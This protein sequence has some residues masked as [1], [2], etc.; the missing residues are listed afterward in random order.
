MS[1]ARTLGTNVVIW[2]VMCAVI[3]WIAGLV[4]QRC[5]AIDT[6]VTR[7]RSFERDARVYHRL[8]IRRWKDRLPESN[9]LGRGQRSSKRTLNGRSAV[10][11]FVAETRRAE[12]V[13]WAILCSGP[14]FF[15]WSPNWVARTMTLF[16]IAFNLPFISVQRFNRLRAV[17]SGS[18]PV[19]MDRR[20]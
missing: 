12:Y 16:G 18:G 4:P 19:T 6:F 8:R 2:I 14:C 17:R 9:S 11:G 3:G 20:P 5:L 1:A 7:S 10:P 13:H 15:V